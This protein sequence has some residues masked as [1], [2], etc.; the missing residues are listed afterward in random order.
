[1]IINWHHTDDAK[2][3][4]MEPVERVFTLPFDLYDTFVPR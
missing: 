4:S 2:L 3:P 1:M